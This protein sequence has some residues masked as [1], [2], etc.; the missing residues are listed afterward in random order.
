MYVLTF[1]CSLTE[2]DR[3]QLFRD[4]VMDVVNIQLV[5]LLSLNFVDQMTYLF[6][7]AA[8]SSMTID[9]GYYYSGN[10][11]AGVSM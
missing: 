4:N 6:S 5:K 9:D 11:K 1:F 3:Y 7:L 8:A 2:S 10:D